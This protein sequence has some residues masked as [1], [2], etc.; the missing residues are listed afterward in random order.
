ME[1]RSGLV[2]LKTYLRQLAVLR[3]VLATVVLYYSLSVQLPEQ[4]GESD[5]VMI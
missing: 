1:K 2:L 5:F 3:F 4:A